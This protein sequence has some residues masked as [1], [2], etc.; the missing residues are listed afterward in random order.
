MYLFCLFLVSCK[1]SSRESLQNTSKTAPSS[2][3][4]TNVNVEP[5]D[6]LIQG[7]LDVDGDGQTVEDGDCDDND[8]N[9]FSGAPET[10][11]DGI[12]Q[13]CDGANDYDADEDG[14]DGFD[15]EG[16]SIDCDD[17]NNLL[18]T[19]CVLGV[20]QHSVLL[21]QTQNDVNIG[22]DFVYVSAAYANSC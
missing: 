5:S 6:E 8:P 15:E 22:V 18:Q 3:S 4:N 10:Y 7:E 9:I 14:W 1:S 12:D 13:N 16:N 2:N 17:Q 20:C 21:E 19:C 11:Y